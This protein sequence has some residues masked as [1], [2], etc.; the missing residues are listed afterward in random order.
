MERQRGG[1]GQIDGETERWR[2]SD[3]WR[4]RGGGG[5]IMSSYWISCISISSVGI[6]VDTPPLPSTERTTYS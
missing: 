3:R 6:D 4:Q 1:G 5:Q 2:W